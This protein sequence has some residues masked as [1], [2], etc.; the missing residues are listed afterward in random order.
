MSKALNLTDMLWQ[1]NAG[2]GPDRAKEAGN[3]Q[4]ASRAAAKRPSADFI[5]EPPA[6]AMPGADKGGSVKTFRERVKESQDRLARREHTFF[7]QPGRPEAAQAEAAKARPAKAHGADA[8]GRP[9]AADPARTQAPSRTATRKAEAKDGAACK[10]GETRSGATAAE[11]DG[12]DSAQAARSLRPESR[13]HDADGRGDTASGDR[14]SM[15][16]DALEA[17]LEQLGIEASPGQ[18]RDPAFLAEMLW[19]IDGIPAG[20]SLFPDT[21]PVADGSDALPA[22]EGIPGTDPDALATTLFPGAED[23]ADQAV[24]GNGT[25]A[26]TADAAP[27]DRM[28]TATL[29]SAGATA[30]S[31]V[32]AD[33]QAP[34]DAPDA[35]IAATRVAVPKTAGDEAAPAP[36]TFDWTSVEEPE[37]EEI[38]AL[39]R[40]RLAAISDEDEMRSGPE[41]ARTQAAG[42]PGAVQLARA[43]ADRPLAA[44]VPGADPVLA[45][46]DRLRVLQNAGVEDA[47]TRENALL[48]LER[49]LEADFSV[50]AE[51]EDGEGRR[52]EADA[53]PENALRGSAKDASGDAHRDLSGR[54][55]ADARTGLFGSRET[56]AA[57]KE[58]GAMPFHSSLEAARASDARLAQAKA[59]AP[60]A[61]APMES[62]VLAQIARKFSALGPRS[63]EE[64]RIQLEPEHLGKVRIAL[65]R[66][67]EGLRARISVEN[68]SVRQMVDQN[69][70]S[71]KESLESQ[72]VKIQGMEVS[73]EQRHASLFNPDGSNAREFFHRRGGEAA[74]AAEGAESAGEAAE[75]DTGRR[76]GYNTMEYIA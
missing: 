15:E 34:A 64:I 53:L 24:A 10:A 19:R 20:L 26:W 76:M 28:D 45:D 35:L 36:E 33:S 46:P 61:H 51:A 3:A 63:T 43:G 38:A 1:R 48:A 59:P 25:E 54:G 60:Q 16:A 30:A 40:G 12:G 75:A 66:R 41:A 62:S 7:K 55:D 71:L 69:L 5:P 18:L 74:G 57:P 58:S 14:E 11:I 9:E 8:D 17:R 50:E 39:L 32:L 56:A 4:G 73:V 67:G 27:S 47:I 44:A 72:G 13:R 31:A 2:A 52:A 68:E 37:R 21:A 22:A 6:S 42:L 49:G 29:P 65:E 70:A 23:P